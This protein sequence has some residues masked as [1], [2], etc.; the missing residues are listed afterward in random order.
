MFWQERVD[1]GQY[2]IQ[3]DPETDQH[4]FCGT[5]TTAIMTSSANNTIS[6]RYVSDMMGEIYYT[7][8]SVCTSHIMT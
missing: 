8:F 4:P 1:Y 7:L 3:Q 6:L 5:G 2:G